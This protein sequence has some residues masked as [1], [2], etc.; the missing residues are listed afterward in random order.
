MRSYKNQ[1]LNSKSKAP[2]P[3][4]NWWLPDTLK[5][6][7][8]IFP[9]TLSKGCHSGSSKPLPPPGG[10][11]PGR[12]P[13]AFAPPSI[14]VMGQDLAE[15]RVALA[16]RKTAQRRFGREAEACAESWYHGTN[17]AMNFETFSH[18]SGGQESPPNFVSTKGSPSKLHSHMN[19]RLELGVSK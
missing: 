4:T 13:I 12:G 6:T 16:R 17:M 15:F 19:T 1:G 18:L 14:R 5:K 10:A 9:S 3:S 2:V 11:S 8:P 7:W